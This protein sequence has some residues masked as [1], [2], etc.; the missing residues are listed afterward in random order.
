MTERVEKIIKESRK[1]DGKG[2]LIPDKHPYKQGDRVVLSEN[3]A[4]K[5]EAEGYAVPVGGWQGEKDQ[6]ETKT[7]NDVGLGYGPEAVAARKSNVARSFTEA[8]LEA[9]KE[10]SDKAFDPTSGGASA[11]GVT[12]ASGGSSGEADGSKK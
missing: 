11:R 7:D 6:G 12:G 8:D 9:D 1:E 5:L 2:N 10:A 4:K 3:E